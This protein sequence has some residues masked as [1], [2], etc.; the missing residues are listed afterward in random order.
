MMSQLEQL[1]QMRAG[2]MVGDAGWL[3]AVGIA[4]ID[5]N[6][7]TDAN[8][9]TDAY[10]ALADVMAGFTTDERIN[11]ASA[12]GLEQASVLLL[13]KGR[14]RVEEIVAAMKQIRP[15]SEAMTDMAA[16]FN[17]EIQDATS[18]IGRL[19]DEISKVLLPRINQAAAGF[20]S[21]FEDGTAADSVGATAQ[22]IDDIL[23]GNSDMSEYTTMLKSFLGVGA[24]AVGG[25]AAA[26]IVAG[27][28][29][30]EAWDWNQQDAKDATGFEIPEWVFTPIGELIGGSGSSDNTMLGESST[31]VTNRTTN[32]STNKIEVNLKLDGAV[33]ER[34][35]IDVTG[36]QNQNTIDDFQSA[37]KG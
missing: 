20:N 23:S 5:S 13:S 21:W 4:G 36:R 17:N 30:T 8:N 25:S 2:L 24:L 26:P 27:L 29:A 12:L 3:A 19:G 15:H 31:S 7:I 28:A 32:T 22:G 18:N 10:L 6:V 16:E 1:S 34:K 37:V 33:I 11:A 9:A 35:I 14:D